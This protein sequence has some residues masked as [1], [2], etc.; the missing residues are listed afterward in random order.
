[1]FNDTLYTKFSTYCQQSLQNKRGKD[2]IKSNKNFQPDNWN[3]GYLLIRMKITNVFP[4]I[5][6]YPKGR[7]EQA[8]LQI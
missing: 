1:M 3:C 8:K 4:G 6:C 7:D 2:G 5:R